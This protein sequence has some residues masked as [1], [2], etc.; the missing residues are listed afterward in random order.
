MLLAD[1]LFI[2][3]IDWYDLQNKYGVLVIWEKE[4]YW[5]REVFGRNENCGYIYKGVLLLLI[6]LVLGFWVYGRDESV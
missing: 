3:S 2:A 1:G 5:P 4:Y 6:G